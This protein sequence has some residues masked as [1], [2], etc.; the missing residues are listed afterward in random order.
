MRLVI[1]IFHHFFHAHDGGGGEAVQLTD[2]LK[3]ALFSLSSLAAVQGNDQPLDL[4]IR[5][6]PDNGEGFFDGLSGGGHILNDH[7][8]VTVLQLASQ[9][10]SRVSVV[11]DLLAV[12]AVTDVLAV[13]L[14]DGHGGGHRK[15]DSLIGG[16]EEDVEV[17]PVIVMN[18]LRVIFAQLS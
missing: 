14:A 8:P 3:G 4:H 12:G 5:L 11:L 2:L 7:Y 18:R 17:Q 1:Q 6:C 9:K 13:Q 15:G 10:D 16:P